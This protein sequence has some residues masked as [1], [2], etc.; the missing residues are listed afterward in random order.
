[1]TLITKAESNPGE[2]ME[3]K[4]K[5]MEQV[6]IHAQRTFEEAVSF[7]NGNEMVQTVLLI[8]LLFLALL[9]L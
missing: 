1:M 2:N 5:Q 6:Q 3:Q 9:L 7:V 4:T 8:I